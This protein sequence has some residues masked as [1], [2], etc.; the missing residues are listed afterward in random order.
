MVWSFSNSRTFQRCQRQWFIKQFLANAN[1][2]KDPIRREAYLLSTLQSLYAWRGSIV[3]DVISRVI[4]PSLNRKIFPPRID[5]IHDA[6]QLFDTQLAFA[7]DNRMREPGMTKKQA[8][9][10]FAALFPV[11]YGISITQEELDLAWQDIENAFYNLYKM[12]SLIALLQRGN[13]IIA[14]RPLA[15]TC[16]ETQSRMVPDLIAFYDN[17]APLI[18]DWKVHSFGTNNARLQLASYALALV[19]CNPHSDF[20]RS[21]KRYQP[22]DIRLL[23]VQLL[24]GQQR[25]YELTGADI[26][27]VETYIL[28]TNMEMLLV[29]EGQARQWSMFDFSAANYAETCQNCNFRSLCWMEVESNE[30]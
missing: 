6:R 25:S 21:L 23:E 24:T 30:F 28:R 18:V 29:T 20:P 16:H 10:S 14:Q 9:N 12:T 13:W 2:K 11:E 1:A 3:D 7:L 17:E 5:I 8:G 27:A 15:F 19:S 22:S 4:I 26:E